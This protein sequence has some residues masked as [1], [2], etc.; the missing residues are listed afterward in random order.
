MNH[1]FHHTQSNTYVFQISRICS[2]INSFFTRCIYNLYISVSSQ[3]SCFPVSPGK[4][5]YL[6]HLT[7]KRRRQI[8]IKIDRA[9]S[10]HFENCEDVVSAQPK[11]TQRPLAGIGMTTN[12]I[13]VQ[14]AVWELSLSTKSL[15]LRNRYLSFIFFFF[16]FKSFELLAQ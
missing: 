15:I 14:C 10:I 2:Q 1:S 16:V 5:P 11:S 4:I 9:H 13:A 8:W 3:H 7:K 6:S 12:A